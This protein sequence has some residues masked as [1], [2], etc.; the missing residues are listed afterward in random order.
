MTRLK[1]KRRMK[2]SMVRKGRM[3]EKTPMEKIGS[4]TILLELRVSLLEKSFSLSSSCSIVTRRWY[5]L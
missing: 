1:T 2:M 5:R 4:T 3:R